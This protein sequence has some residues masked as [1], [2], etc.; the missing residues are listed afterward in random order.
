MDEIITCERGHYAI[1]IEATI[2]DTSFFL[3]VDKKSKKPFMVGEKR[4]STAYMT[5]YWRLAVTKSYVAAL[6]EWNHR[7]TAA[8]EQLKTNA[9]LIRT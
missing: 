4:Q 7:L 1:E 9:Q 3:A 6:E 5:K 8:I 2:A